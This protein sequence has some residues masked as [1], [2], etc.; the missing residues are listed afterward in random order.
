[1]IQMNENPE[2]KIISENLS[3]RIPLYEDYLALLFKT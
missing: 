1:M 3:S 2:V